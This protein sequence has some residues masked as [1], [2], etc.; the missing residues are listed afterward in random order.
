MATHNVLGKA[1]ET[2]AV[3]LLKEKDY[4]LLERNYR[5]G[6]AEVDIIALKEEVLVVVEV[7]A[8]TSDYFGAPESFVTP[9]KIKLLVQ[10]VDAYLQERDWDIEVRFDII[11]FKK[12]GQKWVHE[13]IEN[14]FYPFG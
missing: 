3:R 8:R 10:A 4:T 2:M 12:T 13:H 6:K 7:K 5:H 11:A 14:A 9:K 1:A